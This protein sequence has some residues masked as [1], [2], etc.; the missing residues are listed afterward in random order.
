MGYTFFYFALLR[1][2][3]TMNVKQKNAGVLSQHSLRRT[4]GNS[5][6]KAICYQVYS[7]YQ[8]PCAFALQPCIFTLQ[9]WA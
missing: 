2:A 8:I 6:S 9:P 3:F 7:F 1:Q 5:I 4:L